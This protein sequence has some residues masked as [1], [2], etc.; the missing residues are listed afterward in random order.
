MRRNGKVDKGWEES[1]TFL[2]ELEFSTFTIV[3]VFNYLG[4]EL[5][6]PHSFSLLHYKSITAGYMSAEMF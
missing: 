1:D 5:R 3:F 4:K 6:K 2:S